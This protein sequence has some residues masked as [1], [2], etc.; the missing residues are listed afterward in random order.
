MGLTGRSGRG[1]TRADFKNGKG[2]SGSIAEDMENDEN[3]VPLEYQ[4][5]DEPT[6]SQQESAKPVG[7]KS[8]MRQESSGFV[9]K[10]VAN[11][12]GLIGTLL[13]GP[14]STGSAKRGTAS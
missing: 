9:D 14:T 1:V 6:T 4:Q 11:A 7:A 5:P 12:R 8:A 13:N 10:A 2:S 3:V